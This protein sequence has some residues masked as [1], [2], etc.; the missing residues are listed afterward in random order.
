MLAEVTNTPWGERH[1]YVLD[2]RDA[3]LDRRLGRLRQ[4]L[5]VS[6]FMGMDHVYRA[7]ATDA[8]AD[9]VG[10]HREPPRRRSGLRRD[11]L[12]ARAGS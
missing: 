5:H 10:P 3:G 1:A 11:A 12:A 2:D 6:P 4:G 9:A 8:R 7:R